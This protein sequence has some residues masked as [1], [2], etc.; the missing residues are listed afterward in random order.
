MGELILLQIRNVPR[1]TFLFSFKGIS[2]LARSIKKKKIRL[3]YK[4]EKEK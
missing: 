4:K 2:L 1:G 3:M